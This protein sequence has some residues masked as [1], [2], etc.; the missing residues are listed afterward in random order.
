MPHD[1]SALPTLRDNPVSSG[2]DGFL[3]RETEEAA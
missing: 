2:G 1:Y 3:T